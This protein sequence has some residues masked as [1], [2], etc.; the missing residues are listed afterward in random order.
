M[1]TTW[2]PSLGL[3]FFT[4]AAAHLHTHTHV[5][6]MSYILQATLNECDVCVYTLKWVMQDWSLFFSKSDS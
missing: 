1:I 5:Q 3:D 4:E 6:T 2:L